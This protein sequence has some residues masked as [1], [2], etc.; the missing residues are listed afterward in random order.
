MT[1]EEFA[2]TL[3][4]KVG[5]KVTLSL[6]GGRTCEVTIIEVDTHAHKPRLENPYRIQY[7]WGETEWTNLKIL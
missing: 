5:D 6:Y 3:K 1:D 2:K 7:E 4:F